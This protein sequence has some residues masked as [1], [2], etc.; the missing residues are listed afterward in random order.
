MSAAAEET[1]VFNVVW[2]GEAFTYLRYVVA[3]QLNHSRA[4]FRFVA[5][6]CPPEQIALMEAFAARHPDEVVEVFESSSTMEGHGAAL[7]R[8]I[9]ARDDGEFVGLIDPDIIA[10]G[11]FLDTTLELLERGCAA[12]T[13]GRAF[14]R[15]RSDDVVANG[16]T[17]LPGEAFFADD[18]FVFGSPHFAIYRREPLVATM[19]R[20]DVGLGTMGPE[21]APPARDALAEMGFDF[22]LY[23]TGKIVNILLQRDGNE[24][25]HIDVANLMHVGGVSHYLSEDVPVA[26]LIPWVWPE[27]RLRFA[28]FTAATLRAGAE[29]RPLPELPTGV[30]VETAR[31]LACLRAELATVLQIHAP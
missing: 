11:P 13:S 27:G 22:S 19:Q 21:T 25:R 20:W 4:R 16:S 3:T 23:D 24:L 26:D 12:V 17:L 6:G 7:D 29:G 30:D 8:V 5:N 14:W 9:A 15:D 28:Y 10:I 1:V 18:G 2:T 31:S